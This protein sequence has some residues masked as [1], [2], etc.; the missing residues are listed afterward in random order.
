MLVLLG[1]QFGF[2]FGATQSPGRLRHTT[3]SSSE[4]QGSKGL[5]LRSAVFEVISL[6]V[7]S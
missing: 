6:S 1:R 3:A 2:F 4:D 5:S 7:Y